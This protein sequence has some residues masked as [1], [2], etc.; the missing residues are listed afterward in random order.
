MAE[1]SPQSVVLHLYSFQTLY[2]LSGTYSSKTLHALSPDSFQKDTT[3]LTSA[4]HP[5]SRQVSRKPHMT[6]L[7][8][9]RNQGFP[10]H[11]IEILILK[12]EN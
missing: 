4:K 11:H 6:Q 7:D 3:C 1:Y 2:A 10:H 8:P 5:L 12:F 9:Q